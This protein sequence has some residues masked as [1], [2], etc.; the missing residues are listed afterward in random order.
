M[1][2]RI[3]SLTSPPSFPDRAL[4]FSAALVHRVLWVFMGL[5]A[6]VGVVLWVSAP[7]GGPQIAGLVGCGFALGAA[8]AL[9]WLLGKGHVQLVSAL[10]VSALFGLTTALLVWVGGTRSPLPVFFLAVILLAGL[11]LNGP[12]AL[13]FG[14]LSMVATTGLFYLELRGV[15]L[16]RPIQVQAI[17]WITYSLTFGMAA[18]ILHSVMRAILMAFQKGLESEQD[19]SNRTQELQHIRT[20]LE[21]KNVEHKGALRYR[22]AL[23]LATAEVARRASHA[24]DLDEL[25]NITVLHIRERLNLHHA[26]IFLL[27][28]SRETAI[29][30]AAAGEA[31]RATLAGNLNLRVG[32]PGLIG[33]ALSSGEA[34]V[35]GQHA[36]ASPHSASHTLQDTRSEIV[37]PLKAGEQVFGALDLQSRLEN[38]FQE[39]DIPLLQTMAD[40]VALAFQNVRG[41]EETRANMKELEAAYERY[42]REAWETFAQKSKVAEGYRFRGQGVEPLRG[43]EQVPPGGASRDNG[44]AVQADGV[45]HAVPIRLRNQVLGTLNLRFKDE[46]DSGEVLSL[47]EEASQR[48]ALAL[49]NARLLEETRRQARHERLISAAT[50]RMRET[51]DAETVLRTVAVDIRRMFDLAEVEVQMGTE[52]QTGGPQGG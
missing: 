31:G 16:P 30:H 51:L 49:E 20:R 35:S 33:Q 21:Q 26:A 50:S 46:A 6:L 2:P 19:L 27:D 28:S 45:G 40:Q 47:V 14:L 24:Q 44:G 52:A 17:Q 12:W 36:P 11:L 29:L 23:F 18:L 8:L 22:T 4:S 43:V 34:R 38:A 37:L 42:T 10:L 15:L 39:A 7:A 32:A 9:L 48:L 3:K 25:L 5:A 41:L 13:V 1:H